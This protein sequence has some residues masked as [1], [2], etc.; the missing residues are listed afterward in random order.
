MLASVVY[1]NWSSW[2]SQNIDVFFNKVAHWNLSSWLVLEY[3]GVVSRKLSKVIDQFMN[4]I[5]QVSRGGTWRYPRLGKQFFCYFEEVNN[6]RTFN[7][8]EQRMSEMRETRWLQVLLDSKQI[9][10][11]S[12]MRALSGFTMRCRI[13]MG[14]Q[15][16]VGKSLEIW[17]WKG[18]ICRKVWMITMFATLHTFPGK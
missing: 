14:D 6:I 9:L 1:T 4:H 17:I 3:C 15:N 18:S 16:L 5:T 11:L 7:L 2:I 12:V 10:V 8:K 13:I